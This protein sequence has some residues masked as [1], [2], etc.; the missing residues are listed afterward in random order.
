MRPMTQSIG[1]IADDITGAT[2]LASALASRGL[3]VRLVFGD[4]AAVDLGGDAVVVALKIRSVAASQARQAAREAAEALVGAGVGQLFFKYC[5]TFDSTAEGNIGPISDA[6]MSVA[7]AR[8]IVHCP[9]YPA[10]GRTVYRGHLFV[11]DQLLSESPMRNHPL[12]PMRDSQLQRVLA[13]QTVHPVKLLT[14]P[15][16]HLGTSAVVARLEQLNPSDGVQH[17]IADAVHDADVDTLA[18]SVRNS[19]IAA[20]GAAFGAAFASAALTRPNR[21]EPMAGSR[22]KPPTGPTAIL[23][24]SLSQATRAQIHE[25]AGP[26]L[27][28]SL[29]ELLDGDAA[30]RHALVFAKTG[31]TDKPVLV[32]TA[33]PNESHSAAQGLSAAEQSRQVE[34]AMGRVGRA[35]VDAGVR[36]LIVAGGETSGAVAD[37]LE[38]RNARLGPDISVG[39]PW[40]VDVDRRLAIVFKSGN[41]GAPSFFHDA[42]EA[43][44]S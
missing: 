18:D 19:R 10:N 33:D 42:I 25:F 36:R 43:A 9:A 28:L 13:E 4:A 7:G 29:E 3:D 15:T 23:A 32:A 35:L 5:S 26:K 40:I 30:L 6:L 31:S 24:G 14:L 37:A 20:G 17:V 21:A 27:T 1:Y 8:Q 22:A 38:L 11:G 41:F 34:L 12:N 39:V 16:V 2:D 44:E